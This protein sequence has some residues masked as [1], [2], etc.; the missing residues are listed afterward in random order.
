MMR[1]YKLL[2]GELAKQLLQVQLGDRLLVVDLYDEGGAVVKLQLLVNQLAK[3]LVALLGAHLAHGVVG[4][5]GLVR[6]WGAVDPQSFLAVAHHAG[7]VAVDRLFQQSGRRGEENGVRLLQLQLGV[8]GGAAQ[9]H[10]GLQTHQRCQGHGGVEAVIAGVE[11]LLKIDPSGRAGHNLGHART[12]ATCSVALLTAFS[13]SISARA[14]CSMSSSWTISFFRM[15]SV[16]T[17]CT[18]HRLLKIQTR[19]GEAV[20]S[21]DQ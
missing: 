4:R 3:E 13:R 2:L 16:R 6:V 18:V 8:A 17:G 20:G 19:H 5:G 15:C 21:A 12:S 1:L 7:H 14:N 9:R 10:V 11:V